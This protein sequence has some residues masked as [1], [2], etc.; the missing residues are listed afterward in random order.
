MKFRIHV[1]GGLGSQLYALAYALTIARSH[2]VKRHLELVFH[3][4]GV[5]KR[6]PEVADLFGTKFSY[7]IVED[8]RYEKSS[9][10]QSQNKM[11]VSILKIRQ[12]TRFIVSKILRVCRIVI[13]FNGKNSKIFPW[14]ISVR[15]HYRDL[16][17][18]KKIVLEIMYKL[19]N[20][21]G[22]YTFDCSHCVV[23]HY[24][25]GDLIG[26]K[27]VIPASELA[28]TINI[29]SQS[30][31][32]S[33]CIVFSDSPELAAKYLSKHLDCEE[34]EF[35]SGTP[36]STLL[37]CAGARVFV[38]TE[39]KLSFWAVYFRLAGNLGNSIL[40]ASSQGEMSLLREAWRAESKCYFF[41]LEK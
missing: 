30:Y 22:K 24:R 34:V 39:S 19:N 29:A 12:L 3:N 20:L 9:S 27:P 18:D 40:P 38:G 28:K 15:H 21:F 4:G 1:W 7:S 5:T 11:I 32:V 2:K 16:E 17:L 8:Y 33:K 35:L 41:L 36:I 25:L 26:L 13:K 6:V 14:S 37:S 31:G 10:F 23:V